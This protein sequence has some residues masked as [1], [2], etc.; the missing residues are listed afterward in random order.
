[1]LRFVLSFAVALGANRSSALAS[2]PAHLQGLLEHKQRT[3]VVGAAGLEGSGAALL[4]AADHAKASAWDAGLE[5]PHKLMTSGS[6]LVGAILLVL[7]GCGLLLRNVAAVRGAALGLLYIILSAVM[8]ETNRWLM[9]PGRFPYPFMLTMNH[10]C[11]SFVLANLLRAVKPSF[12]P[13]LEGLKV[14]PSFLWRFVPIGLPFA[15]SLVCSNWAYKYLSVSFLQIMKQSNIVTIYV[16]SVIAGLEALRRCN[17]ILLAAILFG[18]SLGVKGELHFVLIGF[19]LQCISSLCEAGKVIMQS[20]LMSGQA[21]LD[22]LTMV[23][24]MAPA[25]FI[26]NIVP[27]YVIE[28]REMHNILSAF[29]AM[30]PMLLGNAC[31]AFCLNVTVAQCIKQLSAVGYLL[32]GIV[33]DTAIIVTSTWL[34]GESLTLQQQVGFSL[35]LTGV[36][37]YSLYKQNQVCFEDDS[38]IEG[39][40]R[41]YAKLA[42]PPT[43]PSES[44]A[45]K[46]ASA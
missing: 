22:P 37:M 34:L 5:P 38:L 9:Q 42:E 25:C 1:M 13:S 31:L 2:S 32:C 46:G 7:V 30:W 10:M 12:F 45:L 29:G 33:K 11:C 6:M 15:A 39:F 18:A 35:A 41:V 36:A 44:T 21:K 24:F 27:L 23:L 3:D 43:C 20:L 14:T 19:I 28:G 4:Q 26:A 17:V 40:R 16:L 8:I